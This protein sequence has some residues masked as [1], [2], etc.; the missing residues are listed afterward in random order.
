[1]HIIE[2][3]LL[4][5]PAR[6]LVFLTFSMWDM[7]I[8]FRTGTSESRSEVLQDIFTFGNVLGYLTSRRQTENL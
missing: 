4:W 6:T 5:N 7:A 8:H 1:M 3:T 2:M